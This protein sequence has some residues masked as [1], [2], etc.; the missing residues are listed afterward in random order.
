VALLGRQPVRPPAHGPGPEPEVSWPPD[1]PAGLRDRVPGRPVE[2]VAL[3][4]DR[5]DVPELSGARALRSGSQPATERLYQPLWCRRLFGT[6]RY[7][8]YIL[9]LQLRPGA[10]RCMLLALDD[11]RKRRWFEFTAELPQYINEPPLHARGVIF[12]WHEE[13]GKARAIFLHLDLQPAQGRPCG[14]LVVGPAVLDLNPQVA[15][16]VAVAPLPPWEGR[17]PRVVPLSRPANTYRLRVRA[18]P[19]GTTV[20]VN[21]EPPLALEPPF[22]PR[23]PLGL[24]V[25]GQ[26]GR[27]WTATITALPAD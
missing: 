2:L 1:Y 20:Q 19:E 9:E 27:F 7:F 26:Y 18:R 3:R 11:D 12:G 23:G 22:D 4:P 10:Q 14:C 15:G 21:D 8:P 25:Q 5:P 24:W 13:G 16:Q 17:S 6:G